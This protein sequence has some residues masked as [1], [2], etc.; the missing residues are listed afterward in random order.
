MGRKNQCQTAMEVMNQVEGVDLHEK[1]GSSFRFP[2]Y[3]TK[4]MR[5]SPLESL[6]LGVRA[7]HCLKRAGFCTIGDVTDAIASGGELSRIRNCG[8]TSVREIM[9]SLFLFQYHSLPESR[10]DEYLMEV[11]A[12]NHERQ[13]DRYE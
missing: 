6:E 7:Y 5:E 3:M 12:L 13:D 2:M 8:K 4:T 10:K 11:V 9:E 1:K